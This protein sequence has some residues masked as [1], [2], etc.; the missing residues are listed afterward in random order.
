MPTMGRAL[1]E[2]TTLLYAAR[3]AGYTA[4]QMEVAVARCI[5]DLDRFPSV[6][7]IIQRIPRE[8]DPGLRKP[9]L[10]C[11]SCGGAL[12]EGNVCS[13]LEWPTEQAEIASREGERVLAHRRHLRMLA[14]PLSEPS[15]KEALSDG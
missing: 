2:E 1:S 11:P 4:R 9:I 13:C 15:T 8:G 10:P 7:H 12:L 6:H 14:A 5:D 3:L